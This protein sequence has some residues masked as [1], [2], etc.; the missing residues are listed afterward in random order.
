VRLAQL[1]EKSFDIVG[2]AVK[3][4]LILKKYFWSTGSRENLEDSPDFQRMSGSMVRQLISSIGSGLILIDTYFHHHL[5]PENYRNCHAWPR[6]SVKSLRFR[7]FKG[8]SGFASFL[9][10]SYT[11]F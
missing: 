8:F 6:P 4:L 5:D 9:S 3:M 7:V 1:Q 2:F 10:T 11:E